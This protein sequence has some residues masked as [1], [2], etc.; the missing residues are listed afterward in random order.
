MSEHKREEYKCFEAEVFFDHRERPSDVQLLCGGKKYPA[1]LEPFPQADPGGPFFALVRCALPM[2]IHWKLPFEVSIKRRGKLGEGRVLFPS[3]GPYNEKQ[4]KQRGL[5]LQRLGG[6]TEGLID[7][8]ALHEG[9]SGVSGRKIAGFAREEEEVLLGIC[10]RMEAE[11]RIIIVTFSPLHLFSKKHF[12]F[13]CE[14]VLS[15][16]DR[17]HKKLPLA[18]GVSTSELDEKFKVHPRALSLALGILEK[19]GKIRVWENKVSLKNFNVQLSPEEEE[20]LLALEN[21]YIQGRFQNID[22]NEL[23]AQFRLSSRQL[24]RMIDLLVERKKIIQGPDGFTLHSRWLDDLVRAI[25]ESGMREMTV[26]DFKGMTGLT[27]KYA[28]PLLEL[29]D[30]IGITRR[31]GSVRVIL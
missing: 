28:I 18:L 27:R 4:R 8:F 13:L 2:E 30:Q 1:S 11:G 5:F 14:K 17:Y 19:Q 22:L 16:L 23:R 15:F 24:D 29:L 31:R 6:D 10:Q 12:E 3:C 7:A 25:H 26:A 21:I 20:I 9:L